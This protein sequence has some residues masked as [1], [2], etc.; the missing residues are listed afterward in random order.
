MGAW[1]T[2]IIGK[3]NDIKGQLLLMLIA[4]TICRIVWL[5][6]KYNGSDDAERSEIKRSVRDTLIWVGVIAFVIWFAND[7]WKGAKGIG[8]F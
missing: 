4:A 7:L 6:T 8:G 5:G 1:G 2:F 3:I